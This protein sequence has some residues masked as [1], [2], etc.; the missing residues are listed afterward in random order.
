[1]DNKKKE[2]LEL[3]LKLDLK[4]KEYKELEKKYENNKNSLNKDQLI[5]FKNKYE[6]TLNEIQ[7]INARLKEL[8]KE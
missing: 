2:I 8:N 6:K 7:A 4:V 1:M 5:L 3:T